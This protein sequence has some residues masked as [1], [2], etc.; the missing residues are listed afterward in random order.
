[1]DGITIRPATK[2]DD[3]P[4]VDILNATSAPYLHTAVEEHRATMA[5]MPPGT[6]VIQ[7][8]AEYEGRVVS[9][10]LIWEHFWTGNQGS[11]SGLIA[12]LPAY[13]RQRVGTRVYDHLLHDLRARQA[14][15][16]YGD[17]QSD[18]PH[19]VT[20]LKQRG[21]APTGIVH[22]MSRLPLSEASFEGFDEL[23]SQLKQ[24]RVRIATLRELG[25]EDE[26]LLRTLH[27]LDIAV[28][29]DIPSSEDFAMSFE[30]WRDFV[31]GPTRSSPETFWVAVEGEKPVGFAILHRRGSDAAF[32]QSMGVDHQYRGRGI[33]RLLKLHQIA[34]TRENELEYLYTANDVNNPRM[35]DI[36]MRLGYQPLPD[37]VEMVNVLR[38]DLDVA[39]E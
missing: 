13:Q 24:Q 39:Q 11:Y 25:P 27:A 15:R 18:R 14:L 4:V 9:Y 38:E 26:P 28:T 1:M 35:Y 22:K 34:W 12:V 37:V 31:F 16:F 21:F 2:D 19:V 3:L 33:A 5:S 30:T 23:T 29:R 17:A 8:V 20:F 10:G 36:N 6:H 32:H 7:C